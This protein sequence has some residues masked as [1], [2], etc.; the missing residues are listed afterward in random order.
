MRDGGV[1]MFTARLSAARAVNN[2]WKK[3]KQRSK[4][5]GFFATSQICDLAEPMSIGLEAA[6]LQ[7]LLCSKKWRPPL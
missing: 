5:N 4:S 3:V 1:A 7:R 2:L 6:G